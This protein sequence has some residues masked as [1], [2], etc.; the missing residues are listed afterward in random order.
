MGSLF[1]TTGVMT[2]FLSLTGAGSGCGSK[3][4]DA[5]VEQ[6]K[7][8]EKRIG[9]LKKN[10]QER[11][12]QQTD[13][14]KANQ[15]LTERLASTRKQLARTYAAA[16][17]LNQEEPSP[18]IARLN[19]ELLSRAWLGHEFSEALS[20][21]EKALSKTVESYSE[22]LASFRECECEP[23]EEP[24]DMEWDGPDCGCE[25]LLH[26]D[27][28]SH[29]EPYLADPPEFT[30]RRLVSY[31][32]TPTS[33]ILVS[34]AGAHTLRVAFSHQ[35]RLLVSDYPEPE[36]ERF[37]P[38]NETGLTV[39][40]AELERDNCLDQCAPDYMTYEQCQSECMHEWDNQHDGEALIDEGEDPEPSEEELE[41]IEAEARRCEDLCESSYRSAIGQSGEEDAPDYWAS[42]VHSLHFGE[43]ISPA[44]GVYVVEQIEVEGYEQAESEPPT[45]TT[46]TL[47][48][49]DENM[50]TF[51]EQGE[52]PPDSE[53]LT[54]L[55]VVLNVVDDRKL[56]V[57]KRKYGARAN[58]ED[59]NDVAVRWIELA[60]LGQVLVAAGPKKIRAFDFNTA[61]SDPSLRELKLAELCASLPVDKA[62]LPDALSQA[63]DK[64]APPDAG[65]ADDGGAK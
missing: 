59:V 65:V 8:A 10:A 47:L 37:W 20:T 30:V 23:Q 51:R 9:E 7:S 17:L 43:I 11:S 13:L 50:Q 35:G 34:T 64:I 54:N 39:C 29:V 2:L 49:V 52:L 5:L 4:L 40:Q 45:A 24:D 18:S 32:K 1:R 27:D 21:G 60:G 58:L 15:A 44:P 25:Q 19:K 38:P 55:N 57:C 3:E 42:H 28:C 62:G 6:R 14:L 12:A 46:S 31:D 33:A 56:D 63:C 53:Q 61:G 26:E 16:A 48:L 22:D 36:Q 41:E